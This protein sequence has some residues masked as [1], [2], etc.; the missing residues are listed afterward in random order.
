MLTA[1]VGTVAGLVLGAIAGPAIWRLIAGDLGVIVVPRLPV[2]VAAAVAVA[3][4]AAAAI[5]A[6]W[7]R[8]RAARL[9]PAEALRTE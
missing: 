9:S 7:P 2:L 8:L 3:A 1:A 5:L 6:I 4:V